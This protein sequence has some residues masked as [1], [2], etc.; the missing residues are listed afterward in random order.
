[1]IWELPNGGGF[2]AVPN[3]DP[4]A[5][6]CHFGPMQGP[7]PVPNATAYATYHTHP[8]KYK[9]KVY[10]CRPQ[11]GVKVSQYPGDGKPVP[12]MGD[13]WKCGGGSPGDWAY[14]SDTVS[15][16]PTYIPQKDGVAWRLDAVNTPNCNNTKHWNAVGPN[17]A[18]CTWV[19][20]AKGIFTP[21]GA[22]DEDLLRS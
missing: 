19:G 5:T 3:S 4:N 12:T 13:P 2:I 21:S 8:S 9:D 20:S 11:N 14:V 10:G 18:K 1:V 7:P 15:G 6:E 17:A 22:R 16:K